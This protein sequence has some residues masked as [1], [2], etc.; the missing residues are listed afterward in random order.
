MP[1]FINFIKL[2]RLGF[3][4]SYS[5][6]WK[7]NNG[8]YMYSLILGIDK[9]KDS[10]HRRTGPVLF[11]GLRSLARTF[12]HF[13][14]KNCHLKNSGEAAAP[15]APPP[16]P[17]PAS[18]AYD[19]KNNSSFLPAYLPLFHHHLQCILRWIQICTP[20]ILRRHVLSV[21]P[22]DPEAN[23][24]PWYQEVHR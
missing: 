9:T 13:L 3:S 23:H 4:S 18:Y 10:K 15:L 12:L 8:Y 22:F 21:W 19:S 7:P 20:R 11:G 2:L 17:P 14:P 6:S 5:Y 16:P 1:P 24:R